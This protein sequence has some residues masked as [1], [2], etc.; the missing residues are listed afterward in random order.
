MVFQT[1]IDIVGISKDEVKVIIY[2]AKQLSE[3]IVLYIGIKSPSIGLTHAIFGRKLLIHY[4]IA[5]IYIGMVN[6]F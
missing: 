6:S 2:E 3:Y 5:T 4:K 1:K